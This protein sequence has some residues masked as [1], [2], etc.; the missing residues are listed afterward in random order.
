MPDDMASAENVAAGARAVFFSVAYPD[1]QDGFSTRDA[2]SVFD[3]L[4]TLFRSARA[5][6]DP[7]WLAAA[8]ER[9][10][11]QDGAPDHAIEPPAPKPAQQPK[12]RRIHMDWRHIEV[13]TELPWEFIV[14]GGLVGLVTMV[15]AVATE[16]PRVQVAIS[17][18]SLEQAD[19]E[20]R[21]TD[22]ERPVIDVL[23]E[24]VLG[25]TRLRPSFTQVYLGE[26]DEFEGWTA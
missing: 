13:A 17:Q 24:H 8:A 21:R 15:K 4:D 16:E 10:A 25:R 6:T 7:Q 11:H 2:A 18:L 5:V 12:V 3:Q 9:L 20:A 1:P 23:G 19:W 26:E 14:G 22:A